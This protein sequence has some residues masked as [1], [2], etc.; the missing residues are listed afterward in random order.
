MAF[1]SATGLAL[2]IAHA[3]ALAFLASLAGR[4]PGRHT[5]MGWP[6]TLAAL[7][8][9]L[10]QVILATSSGRRSA[11][12]N[13]RSVKRHVHRFAWP[14]GY[15]QC[16][17]RFSVVAQTCIPITTAGYCEVSRQRICAFF[18]KRSNPF[19]PANPTAGY[20]RSRPAKGGW[21]GARHHSWHTGI[22][23]RGK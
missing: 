4:A 16:M 2:S 8:A 17:Q 12:V 14:W 7:G 13:T 20:W 15:S 3:V 21:P 5:S 19:A 10:F 18:C 6:I 22:S 1:S 11:P 9:R 23:S